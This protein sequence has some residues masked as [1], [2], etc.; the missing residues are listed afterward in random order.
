MIKNYLK[1]AWRSLRTNKL[2]SV[3]N[4]SG[5]AIG[6]AVSILLFLF[7]VSEFSFDKMYAQ[8]N[9]IYRV[10]LHTGISGK[11][12]TK[13]ASPAAV[14]PALAAN[15]PEVKYAARML[16]HGFGA[17]AFV[18]AEDK[19]F[20]EKNMYWCDQ[21]LFS[22]FNIPF[23]YGNSKVALSR[24][25]TI[26]LSKT[27][28]EKYFVN[29][30]GS[31]GK[32]IVVDNT[33]TLEV[34]GV[35]KDFPGNS[36]L[37]CDMM[38]NFQSS[39]F[40]DDV[41]W[42]NPSFETYCLLNSS[43]SIALVEKK[44]Q[45]EI[46]K[47]LE[48]A[49]QFYTLSLQPFTKVH[50]YSADFL[51]T[52][53]SRI[54]NI[55]MVNNLLLL[56][57]LIL[58]I[59]CINY[60]NLS[61]ARS[62]KRAKEVGINK[63][64]GAT[65][66][67]LIF[68]FYIE[69]AVITF[70]AIV[71]GLLLAITI[72]PVFN[73]ISGKSLSAAILLQ[74]EFLLGILCIWAIATFVAGLYPAL[75]LS[76]FSP[77]LAM[78]LSVYK[79]SSSSYVR[80]GLVVLQFT[81]SVILIIG[82]LVIHSQLKYIRNKNLGYQPENVLAIS[83]AGIQN[84]HDVKTLMNEY[85]TLPNVLSVCLA[86]GFPGKRVSGKTLYKDKG[87]KVGI[88]IQSNKVENGIVDVLGLKLLAGTSLP[89]NKNEHDSLVEILLN[90]TAVNY[91]GYKPEEAIGKSVT[92]DDVTSTIVG[93]VGDFN[94]TSLHQPVA[95]YV[96]TNGT[97]EPNRYILIRFSTANL[98][99]TMQGFETNFKKFTAQSEFD[100]IFLDKY[101]EALYT[102]EK[103]TA[104]ISIVFSMLAVFVASLG[105]F[106]LAAFTAEQR[107]KEIGIRKVLGAGVLHLTSLLSKD[108][109]KL[110]IVSI[111]IAVPVAWWVMYNWLQSF[112]YRIDLSWWLFAAAGIIAI[113]IA[114]VTVSFQAIATATTNPVKSLRSE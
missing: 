12:Q 46:D 11:Q 74:P 100:Y 94:F 51:S 32:R 4:I 73:N 21:E 25:N 36:T 1:T 65:K 72:I 20:A 90:K 99:Q 75:Y 67:Q 23:V 105:L 71:I 14:A 49:D 78:Q 111:V 24:P 52:Y 85:K 53:T 92:I 79:G 55:N 47:N 86:Q 89:K 38:A 108:F 84:T 82:V 96:L 34:T 6:L 40:Y 60:M 109:I 59:A 104:D 3:L 57:A 87:D 91:L 80:K 112:S 58:L 83:T 15:I 45:Q 33:T 2:F 43:A 26:V 113:L 103:Q 22:I 69:T 63:T 64:L 56:T 93:V 44:I 70:I 30:E 18:R 29:A 68:R 81:S 50:L 19:N 39:G 61:T 110:V 37:D 42:S 95:P 97:R 101:L 28:A 5:L 76:R 13:C 31:I 62:Q 16:K 106:G 27:T 54:G 102:S 77:K 48:K 66:R 7:I 17:T 88:D 8:R 98:V 114:L 9:S 35:Y 107:T 10:L 41:S